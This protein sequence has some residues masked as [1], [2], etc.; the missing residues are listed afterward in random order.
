MLRESERRKFACPPFRVSKFPIPLPSAARS[1][2]EKLGRANKVF[3]CQTCANAEET[4]S[5][6]LSSS[7][8]LSLSPTVPLQHPLWLTLQ[9]V[10]SLESSC[11]RW[12]NTTMRNCSNVLTAQQVYLALGWTHCL[13][14]KQREIFTG[15]G[16]SCF[17]FLKSPDFFRTRQH[18]TWLPF[19][20]FKTTPSVGQPASVPQVLAERCAADASVGTATPVPRSLGHAKG[21]SAHLRGYQKC[22]NI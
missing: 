12:S 1:W 14:R 4:L 10:L 20:S 13:G 9:A 7:L 18:L 11:F 8:S 22:T 16:L 15:S 3:L 21:A 6:S 17:S 5:L 2:N 19:C